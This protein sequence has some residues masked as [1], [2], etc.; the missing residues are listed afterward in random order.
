M[1]KVWVYTIAYNESHFVGNFLTAY[2][3]AERIVVYDNM[4]TDNMV[5][6]LMKDPRVEIRKY[7]SNNQIRDDLYLEIKN[8]CWKEAKHK[9]DWV[10]VVDFDEVFSRCRKIGDQVV[11]DLD[12]SY[13]YN[14]NFDIIKPYAYN[15]MSS[16]APLYT[17]DH[18]FKY[19]NKG[20]A[21]WP[22]IKF[23]CF[24]PD[25]LK[26]INYGAG[27][28]HADPIDADGRRNVRVLM[29]PD[30]KMLHFK[31]FNIDKY[32]ERMTDYQSR[33]SKQNLDAGWGGHYLTKVEDN[34]NMFINFEK[35]AKPLFEIV[36]DDEYNEHMN[37]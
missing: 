12:F 2:K 30:F 11:F 22:E 18:P 19:A 24:R 31:H 16:D 14:F 37:R 34:C 25:R 10:I 35:I 33:M 27:C 5:E 36:P 26:E 20:D 32:R 21:F 3:D 29:H 1:N 8:H 28:H 15:M 23:A 17:T 13:A 6:L 4:S 9:A 7:D